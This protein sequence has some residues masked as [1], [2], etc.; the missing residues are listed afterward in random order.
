MVGPKSI[1]T[2]SGGTVQASGGLYIER[3]A[4][5]ELLQLCRE[6]KLAFILS[7]RQVGKS[8]LM[9]N[10]AQQLEKEEIRSAI[11]DLSGIGVNVTV[12]Q[13]YVGILTE[14][15]NSLGLQTEIFPWWEKQGKLLG[16]AQRLSNFFRDV[17]LKK[18]KGNVILFFDEID[19]TLSIAEKLGTSVSDDFF[20]ALRAV[21]N[22]RPT[23]P[24]FERLSFVLIGVASP[25][26]LI[27]DNRRTPFNIGQRVEVRIEAWSPT[28][29]GMGL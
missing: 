10:T 7:S 12:E 26:E 4:D 6:G 22:A 11:V 5:T 8:S 20:A 25:G 3:A 21:Y 13:W 15:A 28:I 14:I 17:L 19:S 27:S 2:I 16:P 24:E 18:I 9:V 1:Y 29:S 23:T